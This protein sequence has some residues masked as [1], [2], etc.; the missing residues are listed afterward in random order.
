MVKSSKPPK[1][2]I[3]KPTTPAKAADKVPPNTIDKEA[4]H[5][6]KGVIEQMEARVESAKKLLKQARRGA[7]D[8][9]I[10]LGNFDF[11][12][13][14]HK[15]EPETV[16][17]NVA[18]IAQYAH[19]EGLAPGYQADLFKD[20]KGKKTSPEEAA[21]QEGY[22]EGL[23]GKTAEGERYDQGNPVG[24]ARLHGWQRGQKVIQDRFIA[25]SEA[26]AEGEGTKH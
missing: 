18:E 23:E 22:V 17:S 13:K 20:T 19:W 8:A 1:L 21:H 5:Y 3:V 6:H 16:Q 9:G 14:L 25:K 12:R 15:A 7:S 26:A 11:I 24:A 2:S 4:Y 10:S